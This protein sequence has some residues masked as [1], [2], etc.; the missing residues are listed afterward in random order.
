[1][2]SFPESVAQ[3]SEFEK[4][5]ANIT[6]II[7][8][9]QSSPIIDIKQNNMNTLNIDALFQKQFRLKTMSGWDNKVFEEHLGLKIDWSIVTGRSLSGKTTI[10]Q[11]VANC[12]RGKI[13]DMSKISEKC[14]ERLGTED[15]PWEDPVP[16]EEVEKDL[17]AIV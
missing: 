11:G 2:S 13:L 3:A 7:Y 17:L 10:A 4:N 9:T 8:T 16:V 14:K 5:C 1:M 12:I 6:A 15:E